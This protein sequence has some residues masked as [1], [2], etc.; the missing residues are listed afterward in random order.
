MNATA[1]IVTE[2][3]ELETQTCIRS[4]QQQFGR[5]TAYRTPC[6]P[7]QQGGFD[8]KQFLVSVLSGLIAAS[9]LKLLTCSENRV[10]IVLTLGAIFTM[11][12]VVQILRKRAGRSYLT[13]R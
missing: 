9:L 4:R 12:L 3:S 1:D 11:V 7:S 5:P 10:P 13:E 8:V 2:A 6:Q